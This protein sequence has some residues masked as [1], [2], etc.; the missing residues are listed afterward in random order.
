MH[1]T[2]VND[3]RRI[4]SPSIGE[5][6]PWYI[7]DHCFIQDD[8]GIWHL[9]GITHTEPAA[10]LDE[11]F[12]A[13]ATSKDLYAPQWEKQPPVLHADAANW[14]ETLVWAPHVIQHNGMYWMFYCGGGED[15][16][17]YKIMLAT[18]QD[19]YTWTRHDANPL[20]VD[21][22]DARD[23]MVLWVHH[24]WVMYY[25]GNRPAKVGHHVVLICFMP[26]FVVHRSRNPS[27]TLSKWTPPTS[28]P[29]M[30]NE[31][32]KIPLRSLTIR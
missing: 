7:N 15:N 3:F 10:P 32:R 19:L 28:I 20:V 22:F 6:E 12:F 9:F 26:T 30:Q 13:H 24:E 21:G 1:I 27:N 23:P 31:N 4:Y 16:T 5:K 18:S 29:E 25:T 11:K 2:T 14:G 8:D 17:Q